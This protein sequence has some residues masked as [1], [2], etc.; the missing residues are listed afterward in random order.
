MSQFLITA[1]AFIIAIGVLI[2]VHEY[3]HFWVARRF[4]IKVLRFSIGF[5]RPLY[6]W[7]DKL[8][9]EYVLSAIPLG[10]YVALFGE[11]GQDIGA[12]DQQMAFCY[13]S[14]WVRMSVL[15]AGPLF[16]LLFA[17]LVF[18]AI[19]L[20]GS[21]AYIP[22]LGNVSKDSVAGLAG[23]HSGQEII[24]IEGEPTPSW[25]S[26]S[27]QLFSHLGEDKTLSVTIQEK[28]KQETKTLDFSHWS[29]SSSHGDLLDSVG[30]TPIDPIPAVVSKVIA[31]HP[32]TKA[33]ILAGDKILS[34]DDHPV[35]SRSD[36][37]NSIH[38]KANKTVILQIL[39]HGQTLTIP[40]VP[41]AKKA[42]DGQ[43]I[44][45]IGVEFEPL[46]ETPKDLVRIQHFGIWG[47]LIKAISRTTQYSV[48][49]LE[50]FKKMI[51]GEVSVRHLRG[52]LT[53]AKYAGQTASIGFKH[54]LDFL[55][56]ISISLGV[57]N[58]LPIPI[59][60]GGHFMYCVYELITGKRVSEAAQ[61]FG[62]WIGG[63]V[64]FMF[65]SLAI[66]NDITAVLM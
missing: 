61:N 54:F 46:K 13:K 30:F 34:A 19:F 59:L 42:E 38:A 45:F 53:I 52:P 40:I 56:M 60:D 16:N 49:T 2:A 4:G 62:I 63:L 41:L 28:G 14:V 12:A 31:D 47:S 7:Y 55:G 27:I 8:G 29:D 37:V 48:L 33:G 51:L 6:R 5:G 39:R 35:N 58:L 9:T 21:T 26:V 50:A 44:G 32:A 65:M 11:K 10:G 18:W 66:Y 24:S 3:G 20:M 64:L 57:I 43:E 22:V 15:I 36:V 17:I 1:L 23:L 25:E